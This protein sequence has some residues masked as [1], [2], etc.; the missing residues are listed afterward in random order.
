MSR[1]TS[2]GYR[3]VVAP[4]T[5]RLRRPALSGRA[6]R[7][8][9]ALALLVGGLALGLARPDPAAAWSKSESA[10]SIVLT[11][12]RMTDETVHATLTLTL[13][14]N[15]DVIFRADMHNSGRTRKFAQ[16]KVTATFPDAGFSVSSAV[17]PFGR[18]RID[19]DSSVS[20]DEVAFDPRLTQQWDLISHRPTEARF[21]L[22][23]KRVGGA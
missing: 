19:K 18:E 3:T 11:S 7:S 21:H 17:P 2:T 9:L 4:A 8:L 5:G 22:D 13:R 10:N 6:A 1:R 20:W 12:E 23:V 14:R 15:G 16:G